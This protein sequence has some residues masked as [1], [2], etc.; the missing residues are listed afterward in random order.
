MAGVGR[1]TVSDRRSMNGVAG[2]FGITAEAYDDEG[3][4]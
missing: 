4:A 1:V 2:A 3:L